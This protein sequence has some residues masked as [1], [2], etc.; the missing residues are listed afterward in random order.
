M[1]HNLPFLMAFVP[2]NIIPINELYAWSDSQK[3]H[4]LFHKIAELVKATND[5]DK[6]FTE[7]QDMLKDF[8]DEVTKKVDEILERMYEDGQ[9]EPFLKQIAESYLA[10]LPLNCEVDYKRIYRHLYEIG[11]SRRYDNAHSVRPSSAQGGTIVNYGGFKYLVYALIPAPTGNDYDGYENTCVIVAYN[12]NSNTIAG[13][14]KVQM[15]HANSI[16]YNEK[17]GYVYV[18]YGWQIQTGGQGQNDT[19]VSRFLFTDMLGK[20]VNTVN[21]RDN[22]TVISYE[23]KSVYNSHGAIG[24][25]SYDDELEA[26][27]IYVGVIADL[28]KYNW[29]TEEQS[30]NYCSPALINKIYNFKVQDNFYWQN[31]I[32]KGNYFYLLTWN[33]SQIFRI[34]LTTQKIEYIYNLPIC[35]DNRMFPMGEPEDLYLDDNGDMY[36]FTNSRINENAYAEMDMT[37]VFVQNIYTNDIPLTSLMEK[38]HKMVSGRITVYVNRLYTGNNPDGSSS[39]PFRYINEACFWAQGQQ[40]Y[41]GITIELLTDSN[42]FVHLSTNK[43]IRIQKSS[44]PVESYIDE[45]NR[46]SVG[47]FHCNG[48]GTVTLN[49]LR[50]YL[51]LVDGRNRGYYNSTTGQYEDCYIYALDGNYIFNNLKIIP[52]SNASATTAY[53]CNC[54]MATLTGA[55]NFTVGKTRTITISGVPTVVGVVWDSGNEIS[56]FMVGSAFTAN[57]HLFADTNEAIIG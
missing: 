56:R 47:G 3:I 24:Y 25:L 2:Y 35:L 32:K 41:D 42:W 12:L 55:Q 46:A 27:E 40:N 29:E 20:N 38:R 54:L 44:N 22:M 33:K 49:G 48:C 28:F 51:S 10:D 39:K 13:Q 36:I 53:Y 17:D 11:D 34:N 21:Y 18:A 57:C 52:S 15:C 4:I 23:T 43:N 14:V 7:I 30:T 50:V 5:Y 37:Q 9:F 1:F 8:D 19:R 16:A 45:Y 31:G 26:N 6:V